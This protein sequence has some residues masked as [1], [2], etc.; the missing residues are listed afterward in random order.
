VIFS[1]CHREH[2]YQEFIR[3]LNSVDEVVYKTAEAGVEVHI[4]MDKYATHKHWW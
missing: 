1:L 3:F 2:R 4:V